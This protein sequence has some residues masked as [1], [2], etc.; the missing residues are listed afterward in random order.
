MSLTHKI[1]VLKATTKSCEQLIYN[2][3]GFVTTQEMIL[4]NNSPNGFTTTPTT[5]TIVTRYSL[6]DLKSLVTQYHKKLNM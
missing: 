6:C 1:H 4:V 2:A 3:N 5:I